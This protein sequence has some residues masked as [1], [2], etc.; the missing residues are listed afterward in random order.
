MHQ[1][2]HISIVLAL[3][4]LAWIAAVAGCAVV[5]A[6]RNRAHQRLRESVVAPLTPRV[7][8][9]ARKPERASKKPATYSAGDAFL[10][11]DDKWGRPTQH[12]ETRA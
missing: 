9:L 1:L 3:S 7:A 12:K 11:I 10:K 2:G 5:I 8:P 6:H 4:V